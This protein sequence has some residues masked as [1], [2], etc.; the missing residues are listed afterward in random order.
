MSPVRSVLL[1]LALAALGILAAAAPAAAYVD[2]PGCTQEVQYDAGVPT[3]EQVVG[4]PL[5]A[6]GT[7][8]TSRRL[9]ADIYK[10]FDVMVDYTADHAR[11]KVIRKSF[12][13]SVLG[14]DLRFYVVSS[15]ENIDN[16]DDGRR[17]GPFWEGIKDGSVSEADGLAAVHTRPALGWITATPHGG[18]AAAAEAI[19]RMLYELTARTDCWNLRRLDAMDLFLMPVRNP[20]GRDAPPGGVRT[21]SW[22][23][24]HNRDF[25]TQNQVENGAFLPLLKRYPGLFFID[26][27]QQATGYFVPPNEDPV[28]HEVSGFSL[29]FIQNKIGPALQQKFN[30]QSS[31]YRNY[32]TYDLFVPEYGD[33]VPSLLSGAAGM[34]FEKG[35]SEV[36]GKQVYDHYLAIDE[37]VNVTVRDKA[38]ILADWTAQ[39]QEAVD[40]GAACE[41]QPN[42]LVSPLRPTI[43]RE[44]PAD[45]RICGYFYRPDNHAG[46]AAELIRHMQRQG[47]H[48]YRFDAAA[49]LQGVHEFGEDGS[50]GRTL[51]AGTLY[52]PMNQPLK[53]WIQAVLGEDPYQPLNL[54]YD[55]AQW[56]YSLQRGQSGNGYLTQ[57]PAGVPMTAIA[58]PAFGSAPAAAHPVYAFDTDSMRGLALVTELLDAGVTVYRG[59]DPFD[60]AGKHFE[61]G[62]ALVDGSSLTAAGVDLAALAAKRQTPVSGL[63]DY[64]VARYEM[65]EPKIGLYTGG[66]TEPNNPLRPA[67]GST[68]PGHCGVPTS[69]VNTTYC[70]ALF[71]LTQKIDLPPS[72]VSPISSGDLAAGKLLT[73]GY[74][75]LINPSSAITLPA[76][77]TALQALQAWVNQGGRYVGQ[78]T[79]GTTTA[80]NAGLTT[81]NTSAIAGLST[82]GSFFSATFDTTNP[83]AWGFDNGGFI[84]RESTA[85]P[86]YDT[87]TLAG[88]GT[89]I[90]QADAAVGYA[91]PLKS[92]GFAG[93]AL[94]PGQLPGRPAVVD[95]PFGAGH[96]VLFGFDSFYRAWRESD[97]RLVLNAVLYPDGPVQGASA[98]RAPAPAAAAAPEPLPRGAL[99]AVRERSVAAV[100][101]SERHVKIK[102]ARRDGP[103][104]R[105]AVKAAKLPKQLRRKIHW[106]TT[107]RAV[108]LVV[109]RT[110]TQ[111]NE[112]ERSAWVGRIT[113]RL[114]RQDV[115]IL[116]GQL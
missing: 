44:V 36:Y 77:A 22:A 19:S 65:T 37:T 59:R 23:F 98:R 2:P 113:S 104:L 45:L 74:T 88:N 69:A 94:G 10:Y 21:S 4:V 60:A 68:H 20:D 55:V 3:F 115:R 81:L 78:L 112:H 64:P 101:R 116:L 14:Q 84:Y 56:S 70:Q 17:D 26:A 100:D 107:R 48:V 24:D 102:V 105:R 114:K 106:R 92:F 49:A 54:F 29:D 51:P 96:A 38:S 82:P 5:G 62:A 79:G 40:Q 97:E 80:R 63:A 16:L 50:P 31:S 41:L 8:S 53:H 32:N 91:D 76:G 1:A 93:N 18:E 89:S 66:A 85:D 42:K 34:T 28:H 86:V 103:K 7:G 46:D 15:R 33:S 58:D 75:A 87:A 71:T 27:H 72:M 6:G 39:W 9:T 43:E 99:P 47:V 35:T 67:A 73:D 90:P 13:T 25:G 52:M 110:R 95:Q 30:D 11:V 61:T 57:Q 109:R 12:G 108:T 83:V 111:S